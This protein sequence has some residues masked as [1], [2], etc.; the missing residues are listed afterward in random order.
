[1][2]SLLP[3]SLLE[4]VN[5]ALHQPQ[6]SFA[7]ELIKGIR[8]GIVYG[9][10]IRFPHAVVMTFLFKSGPLSDKLSN[11]V[12]LTVQHARGLAS[13]A[14]IYKLA[15]RL[16][17]KTTG[18]TVGDKASP[19][20]GLQRWQ[21]FLAAFLAGYLVFGQSN[22]VN[23]Q[24]NLYLLSRILYGTAKLLV[25]RGWIANPPSNTFQLF[26]AIVWG[27]VLC[28]FEFEG[29]TL[30]PSLKASMTYIYHDSSVWTNFIDWLVYNKMPSTGKK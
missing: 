27:C 22:K 19:A 26:A 17:L 29:D 12:Q 10:K 7:A 28:L 24:I 25:K 8:N 18:R 5:W 30:Q 14:V 11:I 6:Y 16:L 4:T 1:M 21:A 23:E 20:S 2:A 13:F 3:P 9:C 15:C